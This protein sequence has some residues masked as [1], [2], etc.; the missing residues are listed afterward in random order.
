MHFHSGENSQWKGRRRKKI[1][2]FQKK[3]KKKRRNWLILLPSF[4]SSSSQGGVCKP[5]FPWRLLVH[6][7]PGSAA[8]NRLQYSFSN[9]RVPRSTPRF[10]PYP[11]SRQGLFNYTRLKYHSRVF[12]SVARQRVGT[13]GGKGI[14]V[15]FARARYRGET[16]S[17]ACLI[18]SRG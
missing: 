17:S 16:F 12:Y 14:E 7:D 10:F 2:N 13:K 9:P 5:Q 3:K 6:P 15:H 1:S 8:N 4:L 11:P 18:L